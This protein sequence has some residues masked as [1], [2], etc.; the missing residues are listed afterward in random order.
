M[1]ILYS[2]CKKTPENPER[3][4]TKQNTRKHIYMRKNKFRIGN[5]IKRNKNKAKVLTLL[6][7]KI[8]YKGTIIKTA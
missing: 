4:K 6:N 1:V 5:R 8:Y 2:E 7:F 3:N